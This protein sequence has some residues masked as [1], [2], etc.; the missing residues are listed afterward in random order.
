MIILLYRLGQ[1]ER[2][3]YISQLLG[4]SENE[5]LS[6]ENSEDDDWFPAIV[7][8]VDFS[9]HEDNGELEVEICDDEIEQEQD[10]DRQSE[11]EEG[12]V[13]ENEARFIAKGI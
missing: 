5:S 13:S 3:L 7:S 8:A 6:P 2:E 4:D 10:E 1:T 9:D 12:N 11:V